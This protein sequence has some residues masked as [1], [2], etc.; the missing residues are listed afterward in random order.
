MKK[1]SIAILVAALAV[2]LMVSGAAGRARSPR[3][4][5]RTSASC[6]RTRSRRSAGRQFDKP[7]LVAAFKKAELTTSVV[8]ADS[9]AAEAAAAG[10]AVPRERR[11]GRHPRLA[12]RRHV[13]RHREEV[14]GCAVAKAIE[15]DR[16]VGRPPASDLHLVRR[17]PGRS[18]PQGTGVI[19]G[20]RAN[21][22]VQCEA[23]SSPSC[24]AA[25]RTTTRSSSRAGTT[26]IL[27]P[28]FKGKKLDEGPGAVRARLGQPE[29]AD[30]LRADAR[31]DEQ[32]HRRRRGGE[33]QHRRTRS[34]TTLKAKS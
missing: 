23:A 12:R 9:D 32:Q 24:G 22:D 21:E 8:N 26:T 17:Q 3:R 25:R 30:D 13:D 20:M 33:R 7:A 2:G 27:N 4:R 10:R 18:H 29:G 6:C 28:L 11:Q 31:P 5:R 19:A 1:L 16:Q 34:S 15:Y 14:H